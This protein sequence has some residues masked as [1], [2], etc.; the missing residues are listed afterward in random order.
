M[1]RG[2]EI[3]SWGLVISLVTF[4]F[5]SRFYVQW[6]ILHLI[7]FSILVSWP[8][9][10]WRWLNLLLAGLL[11]A[12]GKLMPL[13][14]AL[15]GLHSPWLDWL[16]LTAAPRPAFDYFPVI[17]WLALPLI[18]VAAGNLFYAEGA[19]RFPLPDLGGL[20]PLRLLR[21]LGQNSLLIYLI[22][23]PIMITLLVLAGVVRL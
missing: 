22:H 6:G 18:G 1:L 7:G 13:T 21:L 8:F 10:R 19:R 2:L 23:Q 9:L 16:G 12:A 20:A 17:P 14:A 11:L 15:L 4:L 3:F 5:D